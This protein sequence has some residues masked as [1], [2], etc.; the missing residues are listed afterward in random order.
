MEG[1]TVGIQPDDSAGAD[2]VAGLLGTHRICLWPLFDFEEARAEYRDGNGRAADDFSHDVG[3]VI[4][5]DELE[6]D[7]EQAG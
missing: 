2:I 4:A 5:E 6:E 7:Q 1:R 3:A